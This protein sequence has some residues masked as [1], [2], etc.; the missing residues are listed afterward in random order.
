MV[1]LKHEINLLYS[2]MD[3]VYVTKLKCPQEY[4]IQRPGRGDGNN[5]LSMVTTE[6]LSLCSLTLH[7]IN[8]NISGTVGLI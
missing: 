4:R 2:S 7:H 1:W 3:V 6:G 5:L 8:S